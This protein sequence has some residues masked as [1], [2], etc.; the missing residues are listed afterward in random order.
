MP[1]A[2]TVD[3]HSDAAQLLRLFVAARKTGGS[4][5]LD[6]V[7]ANA[8][9]VLDALADA[10]GRVAELEDM[11]TAAYAE[12]VFEAMRLR[13][14]EIRKGSFEMDLAEAEEI[15]TSFVAAARTMLGD[16]PNYAESAMGFDG[17]KV[18][19]E[20]KLAG[21][22][23][24]WF[25]LTVQRHHGSTPH[26]L[27]QRAE[28]ERDAALARVTELEAELKRREETRPC[29]IPLPHRPH[30]WMAARHS[31]QCPGVSE[32]AESVA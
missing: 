5:D 13:S 1:E 6:V 24:N 14:L 22:L 3:T 18:S 17:N 16:A 2:M 12:K 4:Y 8:A 9:A 28:T 10:E 26:D 23:E 15:L 25:V 11:G 30:Q 7:A 19:F 32:T 31:I 20:V 21:S 29:G 27:R